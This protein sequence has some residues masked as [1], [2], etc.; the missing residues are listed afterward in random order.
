MANKTSICSDAALFLGSSPIS[1]LEENT[2]QAMI[3]SNLF[4]DVVNDLLRVYPWSFALKRVRLSPLTSGPAFGFK[5]EFNVPSDLIRLMAV[6]PKIPFKLESNK[7]LADINSI[8]VLYVF[9]N[10]NIDAWSPD[11]IMAVKYQ[12]AS[13]AAYPITKS[14]SRVQTLEQLAQRKLAI[15]KQNNSF[16]NQPQS[17]DGDF[18][19]SARF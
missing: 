11:F 8:S 13:Q 18:L 16:E 17:I 2:T 12:L 5:Y 10:E 4:D 9:K 14:D 1:D 6:Y 7:I 19:L 15:A 3:F